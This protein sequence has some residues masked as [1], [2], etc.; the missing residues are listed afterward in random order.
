[1]RKRKQVWI[2]PPLQLQIL[3]YVLM[4]VTASLLLV[5]FTIVYSLRSAST[6]SRQLFH[7]IAWILQ[8]VRGP[9]LLSSCLAILA[10]G[11]LTIFWSHRFAGPL[12]VLSAAMERLQKGNFT[13]ALRIRSTD[14]HHELVEEFSRMQNHLRHSLQ[15]DKKRVEDLSQKVDGISSKLSREHAAQEELSAVAA[16][17]KDL[18][19]EYQL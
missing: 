16:K 15:K 19:S 5:T 10:S 1:M 2:D 14:T 12:R 18:Y 3:C 13:G 6:E 8:T 17:L 11:L 9:L 7:S 4:L